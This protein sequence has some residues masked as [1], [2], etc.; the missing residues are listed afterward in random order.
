ML[1]FF[2]HSVKF[3]NKSYLYATESLVIR[4][5]F[6]VHI[7]L[8]FFFFSPYPCNEIKWMICIIIMRWFFSYLFTS[9]FTISFSFS[10]YYHHYHYHYYFFVL[11]NLFYLQF[12]Y[13]FIS[14]FCFPSQ[15]PLYFL[16]P[17]PLPLF[18]PFPLFFLHFPF[19]LFP[20]YHNI[21]PFPLPL[22]LLYSLPSPSLSP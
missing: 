2:S 19:I 21:T 4:H 10:H 16:L 17:S 9:I 6:I 1:L 13:C 3:H 20:H 12:F 22:L 8:P 18:S 5:I 7:S 15:F 11:I 14:F